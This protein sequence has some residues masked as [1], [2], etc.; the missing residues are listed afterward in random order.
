MENN[1]NHLTDLLLFLASFILLLLDSYLNTYKVLLENGLTVKALD[2][3]VLA[4]YNAKILIDYGLNTKLILLALLVL[5]SF[6]QRPKKRIE[7]NK[8][9]LFSIGF[10]GIS[11]FFLPVIMKYHGIMYPFFSL[12]GFLMIGYFTIIIQKFIKSRHMK[13][14][15]D[16]EAREFEQNEKL[17]ENEYSVNLPYK[18]KYKNKI[19]NGWINIVN[20]FRGFLVTGIP[21][22]GKTYATLEEAIRQLAQKG[23]SMCVY[24][25]KYPDLTQSTY[26]Y[27]NEYY[28]CY[29]VKPSFHVINLDDPRKSNR[30]NPLQP[31]LLTDFTDAMESASSIMLGLN[32]TWIKKQGDF[33][34]ESP[35]NMVSCAIWALK[36][37]HEAL[38]EQLCT[39]PHLIEFISLDY[40]TMFGCLTAFDDT[41]ISNIMSPFLSAWESKTMEQLEGQIAS[42]RLGL[43]RITDKTVY[44]TMNGNDFSLDINNPVEPKILCLANNGDRQKIYGVVISLYATRMIR[45]INKKGKRKTALFF[46]ELPTIFLGTGTLDNLIATARSNLIATF[47]GIQDFT[48]TFRDYGKEVAEAIISICGNVITGM[49]SEK[50]AESFSKKIGKIKVR[51]ESVNISRNDT[52]VNMSEAMEP[53]A[54]VEVLAKLGQ[55]ELAGIVADN[56]D[57]S[58]PIEK[59]A[60]IGKVDINP[61]LKKLSKKHKLPDIT[62]INESVELDELL[63]QNLE[64]IRL[65]IKKIALILN[66][67][68]PYDKITDYETINENIKKYILITRNKKKNKIIKLVTEQGYEKLVDNI[69]NYYIKE[70]EEIIDQLNEEVPDKTKIKSITEYLAN[71]TREKIN[72]EVN[73]IVEQETIEF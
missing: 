63:E 57:Q 59:K 11:I 16:I 65:S 20:P 13:D 51:R 19:H 26:S 9:R 64:N 58:I 73:G 70:A 67:R 60:F 8:L 29:D 49:V 1:K 21:G 27:V 35:I 68:I 18:F 2:K 69:T 41:S 33:F 25:Y 17:M 31:E 40:N 7:I 45:L 44:W 30:C 72:D 56:Y 43:S 5:I 39:F 53:I 55:G 23:F 71:A 38:G 14:R 12:T 46:D 61:Q 4:L 52:T 34:V 24:D 42:V 66:F 50:T 47:I 62:E 48:Q 3:V 32:P 10:L 6:G 54:P 36:L 37:T 15:F 28:D 22:S